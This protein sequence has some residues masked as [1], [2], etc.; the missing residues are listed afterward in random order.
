MNSRLFSPVAVYLLADH[1]Q[2]F[3]S[4][5]AGHV[6]N[7]PPVERNKGSSSPL[8]FYP[9]T[10][11]H[12]T[13]NSDAV[14]FFSCLFTFSF[15]CARNLW[16]VRKNFLYSFFPCIFMLKKNLNRPDS[17]LYIFE[18][19]FMP[20]SRIFHLWGSS[21]K[22]GGRK[23]SK[24]LRKPSTH[25]HTWQKVPTSSLLLENSSRKIEQ[26]IGNP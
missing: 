16:L 1:E 19:F 13:V 22:Y 24:A 4:E 21:Q 17:F 20:S 8:T 7:C 14:Y 6:G 26:K 11:E 23:M 2:L 10:D 25:S 18:M 3:L 9:E 5:V 12:L 15:H